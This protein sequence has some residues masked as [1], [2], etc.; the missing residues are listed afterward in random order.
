[1]CWACIFTCGCPREAAPC[2]TLLVTASQGDQESMAFSYVFLLPLAGHTQA[3]YFC[4]CWGLG[5]AIQTE[6]TSPGVHSRSQV[7]TGAKVALVTHPQ[8][9]FVPTSLAVLAW[10]QTW[11][12]KILCILI[13]FPPQC[14]EL[15]TG[16]ITLPD[17]KQGVER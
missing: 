14:Q 10:G 17:R 15:I 6:A 5:S 3:Q 7:K 16:T 11:S 13:K 2:G 12:L 8:V 4:S 1:M 9:L